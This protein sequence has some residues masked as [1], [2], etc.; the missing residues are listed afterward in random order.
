MNSRVFLKDGEEVFHESLYQKFKNLNVKTILSGD[1]LDEFL[2]GYQNKFDFKFSRSL[3]YY[4]SKFLSYNDNSIFYDETIKQKYF[5]HLIKLR[6]ES[7][8]K[9][10][11]LKKKQNYNEFL[12][13]CFQYEFSCFFLQSVTLIQSDEYSMM[14][15][16]EIRSPFVNKELFAFF[17]KSTYQ[18]HFQ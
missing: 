14:N 1:G 6:N 7:S 17:N 10:K 4:F 16:T 3:K 13:K 5:K 15:S 9:F 8:L 2:G 11:N 12:F 18:I